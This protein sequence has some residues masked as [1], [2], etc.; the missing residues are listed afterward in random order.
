MHPAPEE[1]GVGMSLSEAGAHAGFTNSRFA[2][3]LATPTPPRHELGQRRTRTRRLRYQ[4][5]SKGPLRKRVSQQDSSQGSRSKEPSVL[6]WDGIIKTSTHQRRTFKVV[7]GLRVAGLGTPT[8][9]LYAFKPSP[10][11]ASRHRKPR[12][13]T[14]GHCRPDVL[15]SS[16][17]A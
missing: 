4:L 17:G 10:A 5:P 9:K 12:L 13:G 14:H 3:I 8:R 7:L 6:G 2:R 16:W 1:M 15:Q 11:K